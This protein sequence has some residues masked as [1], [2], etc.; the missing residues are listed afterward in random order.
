M[1]M[2]TTNAVA[3]F[4][5]AADNFLWM[6]LGLCGATASANTGSRLAISLSTTSDYYL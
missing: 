6:E 2:G 1:G 3:P 4:G 5:L